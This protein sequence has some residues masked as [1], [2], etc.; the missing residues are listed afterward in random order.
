MCYAS[1]MPGRASKS[2]NK[3]PTIIHGPKVERYFVVDN[4]LFSDAQLS[5]EARGLMGYLLSKPEDWRVRFYD[6]VA[7]GPAGQHK[8][9]RMLRELEDAGYLRRKRL[10]RPNGAFDWE[11]TVFETP[12]LGPVAARHPEF[13]DGRARI[14]RPA[15]KKPRGDPEIPDDLANYQSSP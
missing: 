7:H 15:A 1:E 4:A 3:K 2:P 13:P 6:L 8:V 5:W 9:Q 10:K 14:P 12:S 11:T